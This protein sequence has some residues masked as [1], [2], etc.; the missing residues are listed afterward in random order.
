MYTYA[1]YALQACCHLHR[2]AEYSCRIGLKRRGKN[3]SVTMSER[4][5]ASR[6]NRAGESTEKARSKFSDRGGVFLKML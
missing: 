1:R 2:V 6:E 3:L 5:F 4:A